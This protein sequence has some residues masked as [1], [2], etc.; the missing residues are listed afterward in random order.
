MVA[1]ADG[2]FLSPDN[3]CYTFDHRAN[4][5]SRGE[6]VAVVIVKPLS[7]ALRDGDTVR[8]V[9]RA[10][11]LNQDGRTHSGIT[12]PNPAAQEQLIRQVYKNGGLSMARTR[13]F[14]AHGTGMTLHSAP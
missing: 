11:G 6:G 5:Y 7:L 9:I 1:M 12:Q 8:S 10:T 3:L 14:E 4:G 2:G 13:Y